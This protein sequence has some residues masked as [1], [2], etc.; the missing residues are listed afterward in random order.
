LDA[1]QTQHLAIGLI[2]Y[3]M[4][5]FSLSVHECAHAWVAGLHG[6]RTAEDRITL[7]PL[8]HI[9]PVGTILMPGIMW[10]LSGTPIFGW[11][12][13]TP[14][15]SAN[16]HPLRAG[17]VRTWGAG[18]ASNLALALLFTGAL[19]AM[20]KLGYVESSR[21]FAVVLLAIG[22]QINVLLAVFNFLPVP[23]LDGSWVLSWSLPRELGARYDKLVEPL[24][25]WVLLILFIPLNYLVVGPITAVVT[26]LL[27]ALID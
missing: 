7:N 25:G 13:P 8:E 16:L 18:P 21:D 23:P 17:V 5:L 9:D 12:K 11:A 19:F 20:N 10:M 1:S 6:D 15:Q 26:S 2:A 14:V 27:F 4:L 22:I 3:V 24:G